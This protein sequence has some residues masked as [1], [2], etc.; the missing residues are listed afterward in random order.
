VGIGGKSEHEAAGREELG[1]SVAIL[2]AV[3]LPR[4]STHIKVPVGRYADALRVVE[5]VAERLQFV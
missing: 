2:D 5:S 1:E 3:Q 4:L